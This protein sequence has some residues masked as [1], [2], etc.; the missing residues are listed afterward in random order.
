MQ[1]SSGG[2]PLVSP[3]VQTLGLKMKGALVE[4]GLVAK[5]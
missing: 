3:P 5:V 4:K 1:R 2:V